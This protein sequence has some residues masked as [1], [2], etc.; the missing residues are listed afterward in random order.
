M[1]KITVLVVE[2]EAL[3]RMGTAYMLQDAGYGV[4]EAADADS[5]IG[6]LENRTDIRVVLT[7]IK[8]PGM[9]CG[10]KLA[11]A[12]FD[13]WPPIH[14]IVT[15]GLSIPSEAEFPGIARFIR[16]P[17]TPDDILRTLDELL[18]PSP[19]PYR[20]LRNVKQNYGKVACDGRPHFG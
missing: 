8:M 16:K 17:Y 9:L 1:K 19:A 11:R 3:I 13:R 18:G 14:L 5:A 2:D 12:V 15:S 20:Y 6:I 10:L 4:V 7:D